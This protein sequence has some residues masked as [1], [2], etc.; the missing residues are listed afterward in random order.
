MYPQDYMNNCAIEKEKKYIYH[1]ILYSILNHIFIVCIKNIT[2]VL[3]TLYILDFILTCT[4]YI[5]HIRFHNNLHFVHC[6]CTFYV[7]NRFHI[8]LYFVHYTYYI[9]FIL[10]CT[11]YIRNTFK[12][13][14]QPVLC[15][16]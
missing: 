14:Y 4:F 13:S 15:T 5:K 11:L 10:T 12:I 1:I 9:D 7:R 6:T 16:N 2:Y 8:T 3:R